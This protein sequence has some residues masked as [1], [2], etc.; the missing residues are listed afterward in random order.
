MLKIT[1]KNRI[2]ALALLL[3]FALVVTISVFLFTPNRSEI[4]VPG[5]VAM[6][7]EDIDISVGF[8]NYFYSAATSPEI[9]ANMEKMYDGF[10]GS[11]PLQEQIFSEESGETWADYISDTVDEQISYLVKAYSM[12]KM[13]SISVFKE[14]EERIDSI[15]DSLN[16][17][18]DRLSISVD[19]YTEITYGKFVGEKTVRKIL[20]MSYIAQNLYE[21]YFSEYEITQE[22]YREFR[23]KNEKEL[24]YSEFI[25]CEFN[26]EDGEKENLKR[27][28][29]KFLQSEISPNEIEEKINEAFPKYDK[30]VSEEKTTFSEYS[31]CE[32]ISDWSFDLLR[33]AGDRILLEDSE[34]G[35][36]YIV[37]MI[38][39]A[40]V[41]ETVTCSARELTMR[42]TDF[43]SEDLLRSTVAYVEEQ[44]NKSTEKE[45]LM[46]VYSDIY[47]NNDESDS[48][49]GGLIVNVNFGSGVV[50]NWLYA[51]EREKGDIKCFENDVGNYI[52]MFVD[53]K[54]SW[55]FIAD[56]EIIEE[57]FENNT[58]NANLERKYAFRY[59]EG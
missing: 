42:F 23:N 40:Y 15:I 53:K 35:N 25:F 21:H 39:D 19:S 50:E 34:S 37:F 3:A 46:A 18:A 20:E 2:T 5:N 26:V 8:Y 48:L 7:V 41:N 11:L 32:A 29:Q 28:I 47:M 16:D 52:I 36:I 45:Y 10:D 44:I 56:R 54:P 30:T 24:I 12:G 49:N 55:Q 58:N 9:M 22:E 14:Q 33:E 43:E 57:S 13:Q 6:T 27:Q 59:T 51:D 31:G 4:L 1:D 17:E 38:T